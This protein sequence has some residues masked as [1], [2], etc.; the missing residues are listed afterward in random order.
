MVTLAVAGG[1]TEEAARKRYAERHP[2][3]RVGRDS[4]IGNAV[5]FLASD[6]SAFMTGSELVV[7]GGMTAL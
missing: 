3:K 5:V 2:M 4:D 7:D 6:R 1:E